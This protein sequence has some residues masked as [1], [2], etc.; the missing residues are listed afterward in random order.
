MHF[1]FIS[2]GVQNKEHLKEA[3]RRLLGRRRV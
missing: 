2:S 1:A 3:G